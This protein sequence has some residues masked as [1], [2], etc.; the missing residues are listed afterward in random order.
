MLT[1]SAT[2]VCVYI[3][4]S[5]FPKTFL[6]ESLRIQNPNGSGLILVML[7]QQ[8]SREKGADSLKTSRIHQRHCVLLMRFKKTHTHKI[9][10]SSELIFG[11]RRYAVLKIHMQQ[12]A[13]SLKCDLTY[14]LLL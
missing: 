10:Y 5:D 13:A 12:R 6:I 7:K 4:H 2:F 9:E 11:A 1:V 8:W 14:C 3:F